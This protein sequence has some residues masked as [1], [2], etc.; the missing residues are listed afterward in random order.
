MLKFFRKIRQNLLSEN[1]F[2]NYFLY[3]I[4][5]ILL[6]VIGILIALQ[7]NNWNQDQQD[8]S[9]S[10]NFLMRIKLD[11]E[12]DT[13]ILNQ[14]I[15]LGEELCK[16]YLAY[17]KKMHQQQQNQEEY[18]QL[19]SSVRT[20]VDELVLNDIAYS[21][22]INTGSLNLLFNPM[23][24]DEI[25]QYY[26]NYKLVASRI[27]E[28][29]GSNRELLNTVNKTVPNF[30]YAFRGFR[31][32]LPVEFLKDSEHM[33]YKSDWDYINNPESISFKLIENTIYYYY[34]KQMILKP[35]FLDLIEKADEIL[36][37]LEKEIQ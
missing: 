24:K 22:L 20:N 10:N 30:K 14:K 26:R 25:T 32:F 15:D 37:I 11:I 23:L 17:I 34:A 28:L 9:L 1:K 16:G 29:N 7:I 6:V 19:M 33:Y 8:R 18:I 2:S 5:E 21:E 36:R 13:S 27:E 31:G 35:L 4:G 12:K 3:A